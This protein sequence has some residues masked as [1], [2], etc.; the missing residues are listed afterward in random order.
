M[1]PVARH[2]KNAI[3]YLE[4]LEIFVT[5]GFSTGGWRGRGKSTLNPLRSEETLDIFR[6][7][8]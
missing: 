3:K 4:K 5:L 1:S 7:A 2:S 6:D 8:V